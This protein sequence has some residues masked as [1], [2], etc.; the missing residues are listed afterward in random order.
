MPRGSCS[1]LTTCSPKS[2]MPT[3]WRTQMS[4]AKPSVGVPTAPAPAQA[5]S[6]QVATV[7]GIEAVSARGVGDL[8]R[9]L[10]DLADITDARQST[11][12]QRL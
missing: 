10:E 11:A 2:H 5:L 12:L 8:Y 7:A 3:W 9:Y 4:C 6:L 1:T